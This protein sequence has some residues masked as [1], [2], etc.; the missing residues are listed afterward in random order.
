MH[1]A[2]RAALGFGWAAAMALS[3]SSVPIIMARQDKVHHAVEAAAGE[4]QAELAGLKLSALRS[5]ALEAGVVAHAVDAALD[6]EDAKTALVGLILAAEGF[7]TAGTT[8]TRQEKTNTASEFADEPPFDGPLDLARLPN[9]MSLA[10]LLPMDE[11]RS[12]AKAEQATRRRLN[13][14]AAQTCFN[15]AELSFMPPYVRQVQCCSLLTPAYVSTYLNT[16][17]DFAEKPHQILSFRFL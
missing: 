16:S 12:K 15:F 4:G 17:L 6:A 5:K 10:E 14:N 3:T 13:E 1:L 11:L 2:L 8:V 7:H 9:G